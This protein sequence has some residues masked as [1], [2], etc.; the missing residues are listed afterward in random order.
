[1]SLCGCV[2]S[3]SL[4]QARYRLFPY[5]TL[6]RSWRKVLILVVVVLVGMGAWGIYAGQEAQAGVSFLDISGQE[7]TRPNFSHGYRSFDFF[8]GRKTSPSTGGELVT[9]KGSHLA[10]TQVRA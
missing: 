7:S 3:V 9:V 6:F 4:R 1:M 5:T 2:F 8:Y 10:C